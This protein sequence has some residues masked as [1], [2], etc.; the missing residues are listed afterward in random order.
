M[1]NETIAIDANS[2]YEHVCIGPCVLPTAANAQ[3]HLLLYLALA[4][5][6]GLLTLRSAMVGATTPDIA[7]KYPGWGDTSKSP[8]HDI[9]PNCKLCPWQL[10]YQ[11]CGTQIASNTTTGLPSYYCNAY[12]VACT[13]GRVTAVNMSGVGLVLSQMPAGLSQLTMLRELGE[14][15][16]QLTAQGSAFFANWSYIIKCI[17]LMCSSEQCTDPLYATEHAKGNHDIHL[18]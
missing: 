2:A 3:Q 5:L 4:A 9:D 12:G 8:C 18:N 6:A 11:V 10:P 17:L 15:I 14:R 1:S 13:D 16:L 7:A